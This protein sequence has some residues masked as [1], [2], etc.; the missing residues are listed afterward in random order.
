MRFVLSLILVVLM[1]SPA[2]AIRRW[3]RARSY[4]TNYTSGSTGYASAVDYSGCEN[5]QQRCEREAAYMAAN[6]AYYH[7]GSQLGFWEG[8]GYGSSPNCATCTPPANMT[9]TGDASVQASNGQWF[10]VRCFR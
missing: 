9:C 1:S 4:R 6:Y 10:R 2:F 8:W 3:R 7:V 5:D